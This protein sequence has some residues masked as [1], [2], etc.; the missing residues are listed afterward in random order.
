MNVS[1]SIFPYFIYKLHHWNNIYCFHTIN[2][3]IRFFLLSLILSMILSTWTPCYSFVANSLLIL[4]SFEMKFN[5][6]YCYIKLYSICKKRFWYNE[7]F[8]HP[9][10]IF[11]FDLIAVYFIWFFVYFFHSILPSNLSSD[12]DCQFIFINLLMSSNQMEF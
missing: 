3:G 2:F 1:V 11:S 9:K 4:K 8:L 7:H 5:I 6:L 10:R 12:H